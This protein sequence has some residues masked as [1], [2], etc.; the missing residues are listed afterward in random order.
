MTTQRRTYSADPDRVAVREPTDEDDADGLFRIRMPVS[1]TAEARDGDAFS[2]DRLEG[3]VRQI[4]AGTVE[5]RPQDD[6]KATPAPKIHDEDGEIPWD[7]S[8]EAVHNH[9]RGLSPYPGA[10]T[11]HD[12]T[13]LKLYR[14]R[15]AEGTGA[16]GTVLDADG[17]LLVACG[18]GAVEVVV[19]QQPGRQRLDAADFLNGYALSEGDRLGE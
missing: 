9:V 19:L 17:R 16:P 1:S 5:T 4:D 11:L 15:R 18:T 10:W 7:A 14:T 12:D 6:E 3:W 13:R 2:R 8:A